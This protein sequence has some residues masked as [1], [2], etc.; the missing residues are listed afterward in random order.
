MLPRTSHY[1]RANNPKAQSNESV[2]K[3][4]AEIFLLATSVAAESL[5]NEK[6][7]EALVKESN[8][9]QSTVVTSAILST[10]FLTVFYKL[11]QGSSRYVPEGLDYLGAILISISALAIAGA[12][13]ALMA[14]Y[15]QEKVDEL[16]HDWSANRR[17]AQRQKRILKHF[18]SEFSNRLKIKVGRENS[19]ALLK[20]NLTAIHSLY[21]SALLQHTPALPG[22][23]QTGIRIEEF[24]TPAELEMMAAEE[25]TVISSKTEAE[26]A[27][28]LNLRR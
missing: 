17:K 18:L 22:D 4:A 19:K 23:V 8:S 12:P 16:T 2:A 9:R 3:Q 25:E 14:N 1:R 10:T 21:C 5:P 26:R 11:A 28:G 15:A 6:T 20:G 13:L 7:D 27:A 24:L